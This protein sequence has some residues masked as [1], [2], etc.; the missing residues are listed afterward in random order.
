MAQTVQ[1]AL[2][3]LREYLEDGGSG[4][5]WSDAELIRH[6]VRARQRLYHH[7]MEK[8][9]DW[10][11][12][13]QLEFVWPVDTYSI[14]LASYAAQGLTPDAELRIVRVCPNEGV[15]SDTNI[16]VP[17]P[18]V[19]Y[20]EILKSG[21]GSGDGTPYWTQDSAGWLGANMA[22]LAWSKRGRTLYLCRPLRTAVTFLV[23]FVAAPGRLT[24]ADA[25]DDYTDEQLDQWTQLLIY[26]AASWAKGRTDEQRDQVQQDLG[27]E[28]GVFDAMLDRAKRSSGHARMILNAH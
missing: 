15:V 23:D 21:S 16:P 6:L 4:T 14:D 28:L 7:S 18:Q 22:G 9:R 5:Q 20:D 8:N 24:I 25:A 17:I 2:D 12:S 1:E 13:S 19:P 27:A 3:Q 10:W 26:W 11:P